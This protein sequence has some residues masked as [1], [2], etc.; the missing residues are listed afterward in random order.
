MC[1]DPIF[2]DQTPLGTGGAPQ[3]VRR[4]RPA[5]DI[6]HYRFA[7]C[8]Y[9]DDD[10]SPAGDLV[11]QGQ[12]RFAFDRRLRGEG[13]DALPVQRRPR[14]P[15]VEERWSVDETGV[16]KLTIT[17]LDDGYKQTFTLAG[18]VAIS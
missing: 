10:G 13:L 17:D 14:G 3:L 4:Y 7:E 5:H 15:L 8:S 1:F 2:D 11:P 16:V 9:V 12:V 18:P 6:G